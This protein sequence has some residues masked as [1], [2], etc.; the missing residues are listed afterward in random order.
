MLQRRRRA[1]ERPRLLRVALDRVGRGGDVS[2]M[3]V[4]AD[5]AAADASIRVDGPASDASIRAGEVAD[6]APEPLELAA[7]GR[8]SGPC[9]RRTTASPRRQRDERHDREQDAASSTVVP[10]PRAL[11][12]IA[13]EAASSSARPTSNRSPTTNRSA[14]SAIGAS[15]SRLTATMVRRSASRPCAGSRR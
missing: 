7:S 15:G 8:R 13:R 5:L 10:I 2:A 12:L 6:G 4:G 9:R 1:A 11:S 3:V 14:N